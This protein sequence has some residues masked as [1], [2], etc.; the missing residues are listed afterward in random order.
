MEDNLNRK[1]LQ[2]DLWVL[3][4][5]LEEHSE[6]I[7]SVALLS[8]ACYL[9]L[10]ISYVYTLLTNEKSTFISLPMCNLTYLWSALNKLRKTYHNTLQF[11]EVNDNYALS[12]KKHYWK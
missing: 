8:P 5:K 7:S 12:F 6:E 11:A 9:Y 10:L 4:G 3:R 1:D 2:F